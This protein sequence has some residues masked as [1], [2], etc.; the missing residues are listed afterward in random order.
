LS[1]RRRSTSARIASTLMSSA[2]GS[3]GRSRRREEGSRPARRRVATQDQAIAS[4]ACVC[5]QSLLPSNVS[6]LC[7]GRW[8]IRCHRLGSPRPTDL[9]PQ[10]YG[11]WCP[12]RGGP[13]Y[14]PRITGHDAGNQRN[15]SGDQ[16]K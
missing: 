2:I 13:T 1:S 3:V 12:G 4:C 15:Y 11:T 8:V 7:K 16:V 14:P 6:F 10:N 9:P 5:L